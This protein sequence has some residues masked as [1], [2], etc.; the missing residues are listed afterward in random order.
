MNVSVII[1]YWK[2]EKQIELVLQSLAKQVP[3]GMQFEV[4]VCDSHSGDRVGDIIRQAQVTYLNMT[5]RHLQSENIVA[6]KRNDGIRHASHELLIFLDDDCV[7]R[8]D[9][10]QNVLSDLDKVEGGILCGE[11]RFPEGMVRESNY[12]RY[13]DSKHP[14]FL[15]NPFRA[16]D[17][18]SFVSM[19]MVVRKADLAESKLFYDERFIGYGCEDHEFPW[20]LLKSGLPIRMGSFCI[21]HHEYDGDIAKYKRKIFCTARDGMYMLAN[22]APEIVKSHKKLAW[23]E[24]IYHKKTLLALVARMGVA[25]IFNTHVSRLIEVMLKK[26]DGQP[27]LYWP[28]LYRYVL[29]SDYLAGVRSRDGR[30]KA[31]GRGWYD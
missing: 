31:A 14:K 15:D 5:I 4:L 2:R 22:I 20:R 27:S 21:D 13:R 23:I 24:S 16:L 3:Q 30:L 19:N 7:P 6:Q 12:Y 11:V 26:T 17:Q 29:L 18:W 25:M 9:Y 1:P 10:L 8:P 28:K